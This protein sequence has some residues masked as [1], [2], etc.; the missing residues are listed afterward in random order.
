MNI[1][2]HTTTAI[3][4]AVLLTDTDQFP[5]KSPLQRVCLTA[6]MAFVVGVISHGALD[7]IPH[8]YPFLAKIDVLLGIGM[9]VGMTYFSKPNYRL[10]VFASFIGCIFPDLIDLSPAILNKYLSLDLPILEKI[11]PWHW[12]EY[13]GSIYNGNCGVSNINHLLTVFV[14]GLICWSRKKDFKNMFFSFR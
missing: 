7:Y 11:F 3:G 6:T 12:R 2:F 14:V 1:V 8:C 9:I 4:I 13:S 10:V 5:P